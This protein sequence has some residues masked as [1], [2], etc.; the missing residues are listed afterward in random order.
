MVAGALGLPAW[1][2]ADRSFSF[3]FALFAMLVYSCQ[4]WSESWQSQPNLKWQLVG[5]ASFIIILATNVAT[6]RAV[7]THEVA[8]PDFYRQIAAEPEDYIVLEYPFGLASVTDSRLLGEAAYLARYSVW[9]LKRPASGLS[10]YYDPHLFEQART[11]TF[12]SPQVLTPDDMDAAAQ[13]LGQ[14]VREWRIGY[15][16]V[17][18]DLLTEEAQVIIRNLTDH[19]G[20]LCPP[21]RRDSLILYQA[22]WHP[23]GCSAP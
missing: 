17:H 7:P 4:S 19:S 14:A 15:I 2:L 1:P 9:D 5:L 8:V 6:I 11:N 20:A 18:P 10:P 23:A 22:R 12:L 13:A 3:G 21:V 16:V